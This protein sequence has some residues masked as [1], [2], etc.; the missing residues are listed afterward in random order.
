MATVN[1]N[2]LFYFWMVAREGSIAA[3]CLRLGVTQPAVSSQIARL[4]RSLGVKLFEKSGRGLA[5]T[6]SGTTV[7]AYADEIFALGKEMLE[8]LERG[9]RRPLRLAVGVTDG[10]PPTLTHH[11][12][13]PT[14]RLT[15]PV[16][17]VVQHGPLARLSAELGAREL[18][19]VLSA[20]R[21]PAGS[22]VRARAH[23]LGICG[24][25]FLAAAALAAELAERFP[26]SLDGAPF[27]TPHPGTPLRRALDGWLQVSGATPTIIA[28]MDDWAAMMLLAQ[29]G[30]GVV[31]LPTVV[32]EEVRARHQLERLG[33]AG[34]ATQHFFALTVERRP[35]HPA[36]VALL[37]A[38]R[39]D[40]IR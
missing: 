5:L 26:S 12:L 9:G 29:S 8:T 34:D 32:A 16:R 15:R 19:V 30:A 6:P 7:Y 3:A 14:Q 2:H 33:E 4:E 25:T 13:A 22:A 18:D 39:A 38:N 40:P 11:L 24:L 10:V 20:E 37:E 21:V 27:I 31:A 23:P 17:L 36:V 1:Y 28:E 35:R